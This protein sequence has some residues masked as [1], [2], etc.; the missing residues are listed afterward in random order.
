MEKF[1]AKQSLMCFQSLLF[2]LLFH[3]KNYV[4]LHWDFPLLFNNARGYVIVVT[5]FNGK[6]FLNNIVP[7][8]HLIQ[9]CC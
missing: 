7:F 5:T 6:Q 2:N 9:T 3:N 8:K 4:V 1:C